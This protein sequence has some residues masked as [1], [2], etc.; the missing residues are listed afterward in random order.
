MAYTVVANSVK[1]SGIATSE[2]GAN[3]FSECLVMQTVKKE[4]GN[5]VNC[6]IVSSMVTA[7]C[8]GMVDDVCITRANKMAKKNGCSQS[9]LVDIKKSFGMT[10]NI[11]MAN[12]SNAMWR[13]VIERAIRIL[14]LGPFGSH[15]FSA[16]VTAGGN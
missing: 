16:V 1:L 5:M 13:S 6:I 12:C 4:H 7:I 11:I 9:S 14:A 10:A 15:F 2:E 8:S 3:G